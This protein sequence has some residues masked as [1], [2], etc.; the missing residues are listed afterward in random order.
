MADFAELRPWS[1]LS[2][3]ERTRLIIAY[4]PELDKEAL[5]CS[6]DRKLERMQAFLK[7]RGVSIAEA[8][9]RSPPRSGPAA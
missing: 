5:T 8:E 6:F 2:E 9:I 7:A 1:S 3:C 4:Q